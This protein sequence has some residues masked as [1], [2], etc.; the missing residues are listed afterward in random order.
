MDLKK[1]AWLYN[2]DHNFLDP[3]C[4]TLLYMWFLTSKGTSSLSQNEL[5]TYLWYLSL[6]CTFRGLEV[7]QKFNNDE[8]KYRCQ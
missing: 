3:E 1:Y 5:L 4:V 8:Y 2:S 6:R 7:I